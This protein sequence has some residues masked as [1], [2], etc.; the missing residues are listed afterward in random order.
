MAQPVVGIDL[1]TSNTVIAVVDQ[2]K[3]TIIADGQGNRIHPSVVSFH[4]N[5]T[6][7]V[8]QE[9]KHR[10]VVDPKNTIF[11]AKRLIGRSFSSE[12]VQSSLARCPYEIVEGD[13]QQAMI[14]ARGQRYTI[15]EVAAFV[16]RHVRA[17]T[18]TQVG[19]RVENAVITVP[20]NFDD[21]QREATR[22]AGRI[23]GLNVLRILNEPTAAALAYGYGRALDARIVI[24][25]FGGGTFDVTCLQLA[26]RVFEVLSTAGDSFLG[27][28]DIDERIVDFMLEAFLK[29]HRV[30]LRYNASAMPRLRN[31]A[32]QVKCQLSAR[33]RAAVQ[34]KE[35][36]YGEA[37][38]VLDLAFT[39]E[40]SALSAMTRDLLQR[41]FLICDEA[42]KLASITATQI[43][44]VLLVGGTTKM[45]AVRQ[46][47]Q[48]YFDVTPRTD[49]NADEVV[50]VGAAIQAAALSRSGGAEAQ[51]GAVLL[52]VTSRALGIAVVGG[53]AEPIVERN[54]QI[55]LEQTRVFATSQDGQQVV[56]IQ[57][58]QGESRA[59]AENQPLGE[60]VL[61]GL[62]PAPRG[63][64]EIAVTFEV[65]T[66]GMLNV[67]AV[68]QQ[69]GQEQRARVQ[70]IGAA[71]RE[72][73]EQ[74][75]RRH[76]AL[77][78]PVDR[79]VD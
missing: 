22:A 17:L 49:V 60:L 19:Q 73:L 41:S 6:V 21:A 65:D 46:G 47:V 10:R 61:E 74:M 28:D 64:V 34:V 72:E 48:G 2:Q 1:G 15:S 42:M 58:C 68:D 4:P 59:F 13:N 29:E 78:V 14:V 62:R 39:L 9:A 70:L 5:G 53:F 26:D 38:Q 40:A 71:S 45:P 30:D 55:P 57:V 69:T 56:R 7:L 33:P 16:L 52:D 3:A 76:Q 37:G 11:S 77:P 31:V 63:A 67:R 24:Y 36:A 54:V 12:A 25:D 79:P 75:I 66:N 18:E 8:G 44:D 20:A 51:V 43:D 23:A 27:G 50:A 32:E 35:L